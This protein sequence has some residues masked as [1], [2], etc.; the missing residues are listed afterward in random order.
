MLMIVPP[1]VKT[2]EDTLKDL[3]EAAKETGWPLILVGTTVDT[4][5]VPPEV[6][7]CFKQD[8]TLGV[9]LG[10]DLWF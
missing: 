9:R 4:D 3:R 10:C 2:L 6:L 8:I 5:A 1:I 7:A